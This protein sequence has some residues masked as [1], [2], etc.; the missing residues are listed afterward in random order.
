MGWIELIYLLVMVS[1]CVVVIK[2]DLSEG[3]V[4]N[5]TL[6]IYLILGIA[7]NI[8]YYGIFQCDMLIPFIINSMVIFVIA[9]VLFYTHCFA[10]GDCKLLMVLALLFP[11]NCYISYGNSLITVVFAIGIAIFYG[12]V[13][14]MITSVYS[15]IKKKSSMST[16]YIRNYLVVFVRSFITALIYIS[17]VNLVSRL[18]ATMGIII[19]IW[20]VRII[21]IVCAWTVGK[22]SAFRK[23]WLLIMAIIID[24]ILSIILKTVPFSIHLENYILVVALLIC[25]MTIKTSLYEEIP[26]GELKKGLI[27]AMGTTVLMQ[28]S[29]VRGL[30]GISSED[31]RN[32]LTEDEVQSVKRWAKGKKVE[33]LTIVKKIPFAAFIAFGF[34]SY[35][36]VWGILIWV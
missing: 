6:L 7:M 35:W 3:M 13:Y 10:G 1:L 24:V 5:K 8:I 29:R 28:N 12:Y 11:A 4:Y 9:L 22:N 17:G 30:P 15:L 36:I 27:L 26:V 31:L 32:R 23:K 20:G 19:P 21:C 25:Q 16:A 34:I 2:S 33:T 14:L 18:L